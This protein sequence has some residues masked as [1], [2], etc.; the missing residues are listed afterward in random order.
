MALSALPWVQYTENVVGLNHPTFADVDNRALRTLLTQS[1]YGPD[2]VPFSGLYGPV[3]NARAFGAVGDGTTD[4]VPGIMAAIAAL[5]AAGG[6]VYIPSPPTNYKFGQNLTITRSNVTLQWDHGQTFM[7][8]FSVVVQQGKDNIALL[9]RPGWGN[10]GFNGAPGGSY[11]DYQASGTGTAWVVGSSAG[12]THGFTMQDL[13]TNV[14]GSGAAAV[15]V[16]L[17]GVQVFDLV[18]VRAN[19]LAGASTQIGLR[20]DGSGSFCGIGRITMPYITNF[21]GNGILCTGGGGG[22]V[23][24]ATVIEGGEVS[25]TTAGTGLQFNLADGCTV[26]GTDLENCGVGLDFNG[27]S[28]CIAL[29]RMENNSI[30]DVQWR[31]GSSNCLCITGRSLSAFSTTGGGTVISGGRVIPGVVKTLTDAATIIMDAKDA[32]QYQVVLGGNRTMGTPSNPFPGQRISHVIFQDGA[33]TRTLTWPAVFKNAWSDVGNTS[34][35]RSAIA[36]IYDGVSWN[37]DGAQTPY[38]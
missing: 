31:G 29:A 27:A 36:H 37:Q 5:P 25:G 26:L 4:D 21:A 10:V 14:S 18:R 13:T 28:N 30:Q 35:K 24:S 34:N 3:F 22:Q 9:G 38:V 1:G 23:V 19:G 8:G 32:H 15:A 7:G 16:G 17:T 12:A 20:L 6:L 11:F 33:G 2:A